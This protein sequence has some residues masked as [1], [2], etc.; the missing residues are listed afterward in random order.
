MFYYVLSLTCIMYSQRLWPNKR[1]S[2]P[3]G[4]VSLG[5]VHREPEVSRQRLSLDDQAESPEV[6]G[7]HR[8]LVIW[9]IAGGWIFHQHGP[10]GAFTVQPVQGSA[11]PMLVQRIFEDWSGSLPSNGL[12]NFH[13]G[14][15]PATGA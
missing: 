1:H 12:W 2:K 13:R 4:S 7:C 15:H 14:V 5:Q 9:R 6:L 11:W 8:K 10:D 3:F